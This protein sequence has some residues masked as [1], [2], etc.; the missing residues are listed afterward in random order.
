MPEN[1]AEGFSLKVFYTTI[2]CDKEG[3]YMAK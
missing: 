3:Y 2:S 1:I